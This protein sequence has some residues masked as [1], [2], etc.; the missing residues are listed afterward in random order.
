M[1]K[2]I[3]ASGSKAR[4]KMLRDAGYKFDVIP[5]DIDEYRIINEEVEKKTSFEKIALILAE[6]KALAVRDKKNKDY[7]IIGSDQLLI[8]DGKIL[9][10][11][12]NLEE[13]REKLLMMQ[14]KTH[15]LISAVCIK[16]PTV[17]FLS[18]DSATLTM[19]HLT[20]QQIDDYLH[21]AKEDALQCVGGYAI[22]GLGRDLFD[23]VRGDD[24]TIM[25][26]PL[27]KMMAFFE[28]QN[29][30]ATA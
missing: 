21:N 27:L 14:G 29:I 12:K 10:K 13:A 15:Q 19:K 9:I 17:T 28:R 2:I 11:S 1:Q 18:E 3:L 30:E 24:Y 16:T 8:F 6:Q 4:A 23:D 7:N 20:E 22:E 5:A 25:G 26:M